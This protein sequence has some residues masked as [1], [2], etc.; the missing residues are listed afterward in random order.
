[1]ATVKKLTEK[2]K[3]IENRWLFKYAPPVIQSCSRTSKVD[4]IMG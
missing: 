3:A 2:E 4:V 1:V